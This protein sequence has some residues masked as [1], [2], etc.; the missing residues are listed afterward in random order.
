MLQICMILITAVGIMDHVIIIP[1]M[2]QVAGRDSWVSTLL[3]GGLLLI[4]ICLIY[5]IIKQTGK[6]NLF[7]WI[8][9]RLGKTV[10]WIVSAFILLE[11]FLMAAVTHTDMIHWSKIS[12][13]PSTPLL[14]ISGCFALLCFF[15]AYS[16]IRTIAIA[17][18][19]LL[20]G[21]ILLGFFVMSSNFPHKDYSLLLPVLYRGFEPMLQG[22]VYACSGFSGIV[23]LMLMQHRLH[24]NA[25]IRLWPLLVTAIILVDLTVGPLTGAIAEFGPLES[26]R[27]RFPAYEE[28]RLITFGHYIEHVDFFVVYQWLVGALIRVSVALTLIPELLEIPEG[29]KRLWLLIGLFG[30]L[31]VFPL[32]S[33]SDLRFFEFLK[34]IYLPYVVM[35][36]TMVTI[37]LFAA[38]FIKPKRGKALDA[39]GNEA[40]GL[41]QG[42][43]KG[44]TTR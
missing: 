34:N 39:Q 14:V 17:N 29:K 7:A 27:M 10:G 4:W 36:W 6:Q 2:L 25:R 38:A 33:F 32:F 30:L 31:I 1:V 43:E 19:I 44:R 9:Q 8:R 23:L 16:G 18:G 42:Q 35:F 37:V 13:L 21:V 12:Y 11:L 22:M 15:A 20:P 5:R 41:D 3:A 40:A 28:W 24:S 26:A